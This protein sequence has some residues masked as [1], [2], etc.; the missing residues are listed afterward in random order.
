MAFVS[1]TTYEYRRMILNRLVALHLQL[2]IV[3]FFIF[4]PP[5]LCF[6]AD[7][8]PGYVLRLL[9]NNS[10]GQVSK[11]NFQN[12]PSGYDYPSSAVFS[13]TTAAMYFGEGV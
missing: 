10:T 1:L 3:P 5:T 4:P 9:Q 2:T 13:T 12:L 7:I 6:R 8:Q 11:Q